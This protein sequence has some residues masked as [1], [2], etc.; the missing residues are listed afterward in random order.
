MSRIWCKGQNQLSH[1]LQIASA[2]AAANSYSSPSKSTWKMSPASKATWLATLLEPHQ[3]C[4]F[5]N[6]VMENG[7]FIGKNAMFD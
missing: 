6:D 7:P 1:L 4:L 2:K 5:S 3:W